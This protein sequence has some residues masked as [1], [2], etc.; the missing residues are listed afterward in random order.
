[1]TASGPTERAPRPSELGEPPEG[2]HA[3]AE[4]GDAGAE[5]DDAT[6]SPPPAGDPVPDEGSPTE[7]PDSGDGDDMSEHHRWGDTAY[8]NAVE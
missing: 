5:V 1:M 3:A 4:R 6:S 8:G 2:E 7:F